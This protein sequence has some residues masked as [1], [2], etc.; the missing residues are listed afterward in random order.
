M[1]NEDKGLLKIRRAL[2][3]VWDKKNLGFLAKGLSKLGV[4][5]IST[6]GTLNELKSLGV[7]SISIS[8]FTGFP[9]ILEGRVKT[10]HPKVF[11]SILARRDIE[12]DKKDV[13]SQ[14]L[15]PVDMVVVNLY[16]FE[17]V[18]KSGADEKKI[19]ENIDIGGVSLLRAAA[20]NY[21]WVAVLSNPDVYEKIIDELDRN[22]GSLYLDTRQN[23]AREAFLHTAQ[24]DTLIAGYFEQRTQKEEFPEHLFL[25]YT[26]EKPLRYGENPHQKAHLYKD[27]SFK[28]ANVVTSQ[29]LSG[30][31]LSYN[32]LNDLDSVLAMIEDFNFPFPHPYNTLLKY[33]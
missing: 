30:K 12:D 20:K 6:G 17:K 9:E 19:L 1:G 23:L 29:V 4:E 14:D 18:L 33:Q 15:K 21:R 26:G 11:G 25:S 3:S 8:S 2:I 31:E 27:K 24:Y 22:Q 13:V 10:L 32:N 5:I 7:K 16:P 28:G